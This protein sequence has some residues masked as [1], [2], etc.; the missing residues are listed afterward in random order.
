MFW[1]KLNKIRRYLRV[2][3]LKT[4]YLNFSKLPF[5]QAILFPII[6]TRNVKFYSLNGEIKLKGNIKTGMVRFGFFGEDTMYWKDESNLLKLEGTLVLSHDISFANGIVVRVEK[7]AILEI[8]ENVKI[9]NKVKI[10]CYESIRIKKNTRIAWESQI[11]DTSFHYIRNLQ[12]G[13]LG[14]LNKPIK[15]GENNWIGNRSSIMK[16]AETPNFCIVASGSLVN[17]AMSID[18]Y[19]IIAGTP[20]KLIKEGVYRVLDKEEKE[21]KNY[22]L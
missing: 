4:I 11:I 19:T 2:S 10:I 12:D 15:I 1:I 7:G 16:G 3:I 13:S 6:I 20:A 8:D 18:N 17:K 5:S 14:Q 9:S 22:N 21:I